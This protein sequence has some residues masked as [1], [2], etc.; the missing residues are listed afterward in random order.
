[1]SQKEMAYRIE[2][3]R[4]NAERIH[5]LQNS[6]FAAIFHQKEFSVGDFE[7]AFVL[8]GEMTM[9]ALEELKVLTNCAFEN[10]RKDGEKNE[11]ND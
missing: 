3:L 2:E 4:F 6:L 9:D 7:W 1:M 10:F 5:S 11:Q 8:L